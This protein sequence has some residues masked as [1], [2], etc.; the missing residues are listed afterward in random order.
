[1]Q[2]SLRAHTFQWLLS[3]KVICHA[4]NPVI[5]AVNLAQHGRQVLKHQATRSIRVLLHKFRQVVA[6]AAANVYNEH[7]IHFGLGALDKSLLYGEEI[8]IHP[9]GSTLAVS[10]HVVVELRTQWR[11]CLQVGEEVQSSVVC[12]LVWTTLRRAR[13][14]VAGLGCESIEFGESIVS[15]ARS[16]DTM[17]NCLWIGCRKLDLQARVAIANDRNRQRFREVCG[18]VLVGC[19][20]VDVSHGTQVSHGAR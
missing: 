14:V 12:I 16:G 9:T 5:K 4:L 6:D 18:S 7:G 13:L 8:R 20:L 19:G 3:V 2:Y 17:V 1:M 11:R 15:T 10:A